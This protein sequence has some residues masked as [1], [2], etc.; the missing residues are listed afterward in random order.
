MVLRGL[1][2]DYFKATISICRALWET[3][4]L[5]LFSAIVRPKK[6][7]WL[8]T[9]APNRPG[10]RSQLCRWLRRQR[11]KEPAGAFTLPTPRFQML[12]KGKLSCARRISKKPVML[13]LTHGVP[14]RGMLGKRE[15]LID[16][17]QLRS[18]PQSLE[19]C[20]NFSK[21]PILQPLSQVTSIARHPG[22][23]MQTD[24]GK[25]EIVH[26]GSA[27]RMSFHHSITSC[28]CVLQT[29]GPRRQLRCYSGI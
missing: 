3:I 4:W 5:K 29:I 27:D 19:C 10:V 23:V 18:N 22:M 9:R 8:G 14:L 16:L 6:F 11:W 28:G 25:K 17:F 7:V 12:V 24:P 13:C 1:C 26:V 21:M 20:V 15:R 2:I